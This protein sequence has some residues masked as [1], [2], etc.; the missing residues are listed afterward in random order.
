MAD[1]I[2]D[3]L[4]G[5]NHWP[6]L[7]DRSGVGCNAELGCLPRSCRYLPRPPSCTHVFAS[8]PVLFVLSRLRVPSGLFPLA[9]RNFNLHLG[10]ALHRGIL[11][12]TSLEIQTTARVN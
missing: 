2:N 7:S 5:R 11:A 1:S 3:A 10:S 8:S 9:S 12:D 6:S 4:F